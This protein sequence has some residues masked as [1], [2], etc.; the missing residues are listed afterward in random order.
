MLGLA[1]RLKTTVVLLWYEVG[2]LCLSEL[3]CYEFNGL[4]T[5][6]VRQIQM[7]AI[8]KEHWNCTYNEALVN[9]T[10]PQPSIASHE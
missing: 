10:L 5:S 2:W 3:Y 8:I 1:I 6:V 4:S 7:V 9:K